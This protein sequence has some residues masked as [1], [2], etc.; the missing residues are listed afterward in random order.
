M[1]K[2]DDARTQG[3]LDEIV[4]L[5]PG[6]KGVRM[7]QLLG[8]WAAGRGKGVLG[9]TIKLGGAFHSREE[10]SLR[11]QVRAVLLAA[12]CFGLMVP[13]SDSYK[14]FIKSLVNE[15]LPDLAR[16]LTKYY[17]AHRRFE[18][19]TASPFGIEYAAS[20]QFAAD[21]VRRNCE[22]SYLLVHKALEA[23]LRELNS[24]I[25]GIAPSVKRYEM[26][27]GPLTGERAGKVKGHFSS[28]L[29]ALK[30]QK[31][32]LYYRG[33]LPADAGLVRDDYS[34]FAPSLAATG[35][36]YC[37]MATRRSKQNISCPSGNDV[38]IKL[39]NGVVLRG[40]VRPAEGKN[41]FAGTIIHE[42]THIVCETRD[43]KMKQAD[44]GRLVTAKGLSDFTSGKTAKTM[45]R[46]DNDGAFTQTYGTQ[47]CI[48]MAAHW[49]DKA[50]MN[51]DNYCFFCEEFL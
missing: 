5:V 38:H 30:T 40:A 6:P 27:F 7:Q 49:P 26:W 42:M 51:A 25:G 48:Y 3:A 37:G 22:E 45:P 10:R 15:I 13:G 14:T 34:Q 11:T 8:D 46:Q 31:L 50:I 21:Q 32:V 28:L 33:P 35:G 47:R 4:N 39:G 43:V 2:S 16:R 24:A 36:E 1:P 12:Q 19:L 23:G 18:L 29:E 9:K 17:D 41:T 44:T 20:F